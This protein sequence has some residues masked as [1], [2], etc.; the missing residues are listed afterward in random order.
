MPLCFVLFFVSMQEISLYFLSYRHTLPKTYKKKKNYNK[1]I[2][3]IVGVLTVQFDE[4]RQFDIFINIIFVLPL[5]D[6]IEGHR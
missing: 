5:L 6:S 3:L 4:V 2:T 1:F